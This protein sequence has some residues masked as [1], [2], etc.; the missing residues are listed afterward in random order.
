MRKPNG[1]WTYK[2]VCKDAKKYKTRSEFSTGSGAYR[3]ALKNKWINDVC[4]HMKELHKPK[5]YWTY[6]NILA[7]ANTFETRTA[8][9]N[10]NGCAYNT[11]LKNNWI[12]DICDHMK[13]AGNKYKRVIYRLEFPNKTAYVGLTC[14]PRR[15]FNNNFKNYNYLVQ[16]AIEEHGYPKVIISTVWYNFEEIGNAERSGIEYLEYLGWSI[17]NINKPGSLGGLKLKWDYNNVLKEAKNYNSRTKF[18]H[19]SGSAYRVALKNK[20][21][22]SA[23]NHMK[24]LHKPKGYWTYQNVCKEAKKHNSRTSFQNNSCSSY[25]VALK[26]NWLNYLYQENTNNGI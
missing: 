16:D 26:N 15:R 7:T 25:K 21:I 24:E 23:C 3:V 14:N 9:A 19:G 20:W 12:D 10:S 6:Q 8:F 5:G 4:S 2:N 18:C 17:L 22:N 11:A 1:H 13:P